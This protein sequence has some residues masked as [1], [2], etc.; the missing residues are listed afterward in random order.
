[1]L[2]MHCVPACWHLQSYMRHCVIATH[3][4]VS[5][6]ELC[7]FNPIMCAVIWAGDASCKVTQ[8][9]KLG[10]VGSRQG[11]PDTILSVFQL[12]LHPNLSAV[13]DFLKF[14]WDRD[15]VI[16]RPFSVYL[17]NHLERLISIFYVPSLAEKGS[18][19][20]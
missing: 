9:A 6:G 7:H 13:F 16:S 12:L 11:K 5:H 18:V 4:S 8:V 3:F 1:M 2:F 20:M 15:W 14:C 10:F 19:V 17:D